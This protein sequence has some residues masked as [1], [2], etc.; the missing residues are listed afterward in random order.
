[1]SIDCECVTMTAT[2]P[3]VHD[4]ILMF[5]YYYEKSDNEY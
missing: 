2:L 1:M 3:F 4:N 5:F